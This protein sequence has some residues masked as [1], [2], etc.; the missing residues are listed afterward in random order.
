MVLESDVRWRPDEAVAAHREEE[1]ERVEEVEEA[2]VKCQVPVVPGGIAMV[3]M[4]RNYSESWERTLGCTRPS[5]RH[6]ESA[7]AGRQPASQRAQ[8]SSC[9]A[10]EYQRRMRAP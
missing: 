7:Q 5:E 8:Y 10:P 2:L 1:R 6:F 9:D 4:M 3:S